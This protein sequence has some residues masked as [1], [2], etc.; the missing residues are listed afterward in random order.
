MVFFFFFEIKLVFVAFFEIEKQGLCSLTQH[1]PKW[2]CGGHGNLQ[3]C[4]AQTFGYHI[5]LLPGLPPD[6]KV[7]LLQG[8][9][10]F[11]IKCPREDLM[12]RQAFLLHVW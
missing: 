6:V 3:S 1:C 5:L 2:Y 7:G 4:V 12:L 9:A 8:S 10:S 11:L